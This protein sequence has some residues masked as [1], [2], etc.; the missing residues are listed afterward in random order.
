MQTI[1]PET[2]LFAGEHFQWLLGEQ[3]KTAALQGVPYAVVV[4]YPQGFSDERGSDVVRTAAAFIKDLVRDDDLA[5][6][7]GEETLAIGLPNT[8]ET[9]ARVLTYRV[10]G[11]LAARTGHLRAS[12]W[13]AGMAC[14]PE[15][16]LTAEELLQTALDRAKQGR[17]AR[18]PGSD[19]PPI[20]LGFG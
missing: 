10:K 7:L 15:D 9:G 13:E 17:R 20:P 2:G 4:C 16:G 12:V 5:G 18:S 14:M 1:D 19:L 11:D 8:S 6:R 3:V